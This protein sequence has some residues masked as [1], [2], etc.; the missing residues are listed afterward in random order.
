[1]PSAYSRAEE[2]AQCVRDRLAIKCAYP[3]SDPD[4]DP[5][6]TAYVHNSR[7]LLRQL[8]DMVCGADA[9]ALA[10]LMQALLIVPPDDDDFDHAQMH[11]NIRLEV[12]AEMVK[13]VSKRGRSVK[14]G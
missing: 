8:A 7:E 1:V 6:Q 12:A 4:D 14:H 3:L 2:L 10:G 5:S 9:I 13:R 11:N